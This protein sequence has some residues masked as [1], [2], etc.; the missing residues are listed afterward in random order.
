MTDLIGLMEHKWTEIFRQCL[1]LRK[2]SV[3]NQNRYDWN[4]SRKRCPDLLA[5]EIAPTCLRSCVEELI[6]TWSNHR[7]ERITPIKCFAQL[8][9][10]PLARSQIVNV[11]KDIR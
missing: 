6:P 9:V 4:F 3:V 1:R 8:F 10:E 5:N 2:R 7:E 11:H